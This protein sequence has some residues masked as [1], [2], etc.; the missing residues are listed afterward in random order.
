MGRI[1]AGD[2]K[3]LD[4]QVPDSGTRPTS[5]KVREAIFSF[6][7]SVNALSDARVIDLFAGSGAL[8]LEALSRGAAEAVFVDNAAAAVR[9]ISA[10]V[11][12][13]AARAGVTPTDFPAEVVRSDASVWAQSGSRHAD[14]VFLD[15]PYAT[16]P[17][18][19]PQILLSASRWIDEAGLVVVE[20]PISL[21]V[22][23]GGTGLRRYRYRDYGD[24]AVSYF[25]LDL[26][27]G[28]IA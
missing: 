26:A 3:A 28:S 16:A 15:P 13:A 14:L 10:N 24:T 5:G 25:E 7:E 18:Y 21:T 12:A 4:L 20:H 22:F 11:A 2:F 9:A 23:S 19:V 27:S 6:L 17:E 1:I 8:G